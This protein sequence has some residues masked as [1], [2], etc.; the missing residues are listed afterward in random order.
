MADLRFEV[1]VLKHSLVL[2]KLCYV[3]IDNNRNN[4]VIVPLVGSGEG[5]VYAYLT[6]AP[7]DR[8]AASG[9]PS[10]VFIDNI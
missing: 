2:A 5:R 1:W 4:P 9:R 7:K 8:E 3:F 6:P 10:Y